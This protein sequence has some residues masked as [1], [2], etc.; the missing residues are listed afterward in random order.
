MGVGQRKQ[1]FETGCVQEK[2]A[3]SRAGMLTICIL[4]ILLLRKFMSCH[5]ELWKFHIL[6]GGADRKWMVSRHNTASLNIL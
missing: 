3:D 1:T 5:S 4:G 6:R 2:A